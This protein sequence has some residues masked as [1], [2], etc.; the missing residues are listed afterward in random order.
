VALDLPET[1]VSESS[2]LTL[3]WSLST[4]LIVATVC[5]FSL[6]GSG[7]GWLALD[8]HERSIERVLE[9]QASGV[10]QGVAEGVRSPTALADPVTVE[11]LLERLMTHPSAAYARIWDANGSLLAERRVDADLRPAGVGLRD[12]L[13][14]RSTLVRRRR[15]ADGEVVI[16][17][18]A[19]VRLLSTRDVH[20]MLG[21]E[22]AGTSHSTVL[23]F[24]Q[25]GLRTSP[26]LVHTRLFGMWMLC[27]GLLLI[28]TA[29]V[30]AFL[31]IRRLTDPIREL[32]GAT[33]AIASG[34]FDLSLRSTSRDET[35]ELS[36]A[37]AQ[38]LGRVNDYR[39]QVD[40]HRRDLEEQVLERTR[41]LE[42]R[43]A[44]AIELAK[45][46]EAASAA[47][48][49]F[50]ANVSHEIR[51]PMHGLLGMSEL[52]LETSLSE[53]QVHCA[54]TLRSCAKGLLVLID[55]VLDFSKGEAG[56]L[57][58]HETPFSPAELL[59]EVVCQFA[60]QAGSKGIALVL[61]PDDS[62]PG[63][64][65][66]DANRLQQV[67]RNLVSNAVKFT[68]AG[69]VVVRATMATRPVPNEIAT[70]ARAVEWIEFSVT[71]TGPG[72]PES[73]RDSIFQTFTQADASLTRRHGG[74][75][76]GLAISHQLAELMHGDIGFESDVEL[77]TRFWVHV[78]LALVRE[79]GDGNAR[80]D[81]GGCRIVLVG[82]GGTAQD[83]LQQRLSAWG[84]QCQSTEC[85]D[86]SALATL[87]ADADLL[88]WSGLRAGSP[89]EDAAA[90]S[91]PIIAVHTTA[92][93][94]AQC[95]D[96][97]AVAHLVHPIGD[98]DL[99]RTVDVA[100]GRTSGDHDAGSEGLPPRLRFEA[101]VLVVEDNPVNQ[102]LTVAMLEDLGCEVVLAVDGRQG[103]RSTRS[104]HFD[105]AFMD[106]Q[107]PRMD[108]LTAAREI[109]SAEQGSD[110]RLPIIALTAHAL[111]HTREE[112][113]AA[114]MDDY[115]AKP[116]TKLQLAAA[117][118]RWTDTEDRT[119]PA[120]APK[121]VEPQ[122]APPGGAVLSQD[123]IAQVRE[124]DSDGSQG[125]LAR[126]VGNYVS[127]A[128]KLLELLR[129]AI[130]AADSDRTSLETLVRNGGAP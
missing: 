85:D 39:E 56:K 65:F 91:A 109:R 45:R 128:P 123:V 2:I 24:T 113:L 34:R 53:R 59:D 23:G 68:S 82:P 3:G 48:S 6:A 17:A 97:D 106:C 32:V 30:A 47:K 50:L 4:K 69:E 119:R 129:S 14:P 49:Q 107:M 102:E 94:I 63:H 37:I 72:I 38:M 80:P 51:T 8:G 93:G 108:G 111:S 101:K 18:V 84:A 55:D 19:P 118:R 92:D 31:V 54:R 29:G 86:P 13:D 78:P 81:L 11:A 83:T 74:T 58:L 112:C 114:G 26:E 9:R 121:P 98:A 10:V 44:E 73:A 61:H 104:Q 71:D 95:Q 124:L 126:I 87:V 117:L 1:S 88:L 105:L 89:W 21:A 70:P 5:L 125:L 20:S 35:G 75:G 127:E 42:Q 60:E 16:D 27:G 76:L 79:E 33:R 99:V 67:L 12:G 110:Q 120:E 62:L 103:L 90:S 22:P 46:A 116:F 25:V 7:M 15:L 52:L 96:L 100:L 57:E 77:G 41:E 28:A 64:L 36:A 115:I 43:A 122:L 130:D 66:G 40:S